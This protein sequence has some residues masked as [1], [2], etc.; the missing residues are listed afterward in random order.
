MFCIFEILKCFKI[1]KISSQAE[2]LQANNEKDGQPLLFYQDSNSED[3]EIEEEI[4]PSHSEYD[5]YLFSE[6]DEDEND[7]DKDDMDNEMDEAKDQK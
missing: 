4:I 6:E 1:E 2:S 3:E 5:D 7:N